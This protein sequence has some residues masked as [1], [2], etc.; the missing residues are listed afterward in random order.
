MQEE[1]EIS[2]VLPAHNEAERIRN[3]VSVKAILPSKRGEIGG[4]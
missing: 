3:A 4:L 1:I 2:V